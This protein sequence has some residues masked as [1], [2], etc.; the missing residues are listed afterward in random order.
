MNRRI[1]LVL[2]VL[3][4]LLHIVVIVIGLVLNQWWLSAI[5]AIMMICWIIW[6]ARS[7]KKLP[8]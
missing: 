7:S 1:L 8:R 2:A 5:F 4:T 3:A 6:A